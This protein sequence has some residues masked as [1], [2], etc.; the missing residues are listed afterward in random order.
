MGWTLLA[1]ALV[2]VDVALAVGA[3]VSHILEVINQTRDQAAAQITAHKEAEQTEKGVHEPHVVADA[4]NNGLLAVWTHRL[5]RRRLEHLALQH[6]HCGG[7]PRG[8][9]HCRRV[10]RGGAIVTGPWSKLPWHVVRKVTR[11]RVVAT[12]WVGHGHRHRA[13]PWDVR[14]NEAW[15]HCGFVRWRTVLRWHR[16]SHWRSSCYRSWASW[17]GDWRL[18]VLLL[19]ERSAGAPWVGRRRVAG[20]AAALEGRVSDGFFLQTLS[21][22]WYFK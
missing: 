7:S 15:L 4:G 14:W 1:Y 21:A 19:D 9:N 3:G 18:P 5:H 12:M 22:L 13:L 2:C 11:W 8:S 10:T 16:M 6:R 17:S 20:H